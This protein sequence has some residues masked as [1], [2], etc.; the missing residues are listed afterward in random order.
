MNLQKGNLLQKFNLN[1]SAM[2]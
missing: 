2:N 1:S